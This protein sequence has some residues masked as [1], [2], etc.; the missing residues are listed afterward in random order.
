MKSF[1]LAA[2][3]ATT[4]AALGDACDG[5]NESC[6]DATM[7]C[8]TATNGFVM[9]VDGKTKSEV[10]VP[11]AAICNLAPVDGAAKAT[12]FAS[13]LTG[14][15]KD[16]TV[17]SFSYPADGFACYTAPAPPAPP[18]PNPPVPTPPTDKW[19]GVACK[20]EDDNCGDLDGVTTH[21]CGVAQLG[22]LVDDEGKNTVKN[23]PNLVVCNVGAAPIDI[24]N[25]LAMGV[26][27]D[28]KEILITAFYS[29]HNFTCLSG[30]KSLIASTMTLIA[31]GSMM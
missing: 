18:G 6:N 16:K 12:D 3:F 31:L 5:T 14:D 26:G 20:L 2:L 11:N 9:N 27:I 7:C 21:C 17:I 30:A 25:E 15:D 10:P 8:G 28:G 29:G 1:I 4:Q 24:T 23:A 19:I 13:T 22:V